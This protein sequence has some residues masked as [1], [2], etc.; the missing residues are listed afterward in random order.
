MDN[1]MSNKTSKPI[2]HVGCSKQSGAVLITTIVLLIVFTLLGVATM[3]TNITDITVQNG[4]KNRNNALQCA[5]GALRA[6]EIWLDQLTG[7]AYE[8]DSNPVQSERQVW[9][10]NQTAIQNPELNTALWADTDATWAYG[11]GLLD[12]Q[13]SVGCK[14][15][16]R[17]F[18]EWLG[19]ISSDSE[20]LDFDKQAKGKS[21]MYRI[22]A[23]S[24]G[25]DGNAA[26]VLQSTYLQPI[27]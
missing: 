16:P 3:R 11:G 18:I 20:G 8:A 1:F 17:Y 15:D 21:A 22:T 4:L 24:T 9:K 26:A 13:A 12:A 5:E 10:V 23:Y 7:A 6:G 14:T 27:N 25:T 19:Y 2:Q